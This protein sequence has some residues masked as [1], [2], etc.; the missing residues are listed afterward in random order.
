MSALL[1]EN[2]QFLE[3]KFYIYLNR[4]FFVRV[5]IICHFSLG[6]GDILSI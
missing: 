1:P 6:C 2:F 5:F 4:R 3:A